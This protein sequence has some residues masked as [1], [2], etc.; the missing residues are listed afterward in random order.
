MKANILLIKIT[1]KSFVKF[2]D[3][4]QYVLCGFTKRGLKVQARLPKSARNFPTTEESY[5][6]HHNVISFN[7]REFLRPIN[8]SY[9]AVVLRFGA[10]KTFP[11][12]H[13][14]TYNSL[15]L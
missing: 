6:L 14:F 8:W 1:L 4:W 5:H 3:F 9:I 12:A 7:L 13:T 15:H 11:L 10:F 2:S